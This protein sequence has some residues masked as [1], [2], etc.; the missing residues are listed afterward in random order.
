MKKILLSIFITIG[1]YSITIAQGIVRGKI[2]DESGETQIGVTIVVKSNPSVGTVTDLDGNYSLN[3]KDSTTQTLV[4]S[5]IG[6]ELIEEVVH[7]KKG[8]VVI[9]NF[10][11]KSTA[12]QIKEI[13]VNAKGN[14]AKDTYIESMKKSSSVTLDYISSETIKKTGDANVTAAVA[15]VSGVST[16]GS[17]ITVRGI[18]DRYVKTAINGLR[19]PTLDPFTNNIKLDLFPASL[20][21]NVIITKTESPDLPGDFAGAYISVETKDYPEQLAVNIES[22]FGYNSQTTFN[23]IVSSQRSSTDK[24][25]FDNNFRDHDHNLFIQTIK[26]PTDYQQFVALGLGDY[27]TSLG[28]TNENWNSNGDMYYR[29]GLVQLGLLAPV[30]IDDNAAY[31]EARILYITGPYSQQAFQIINANVP[32]SGQSFKNNWNTISRK[33]PLDF[34]QSFSI[35]TQTNLFGKPLGFIVGYRYGSSTKYDP[36][37]MASKIRA[38]GSRESLFNGEHSEEVN[39]WSAIANVAYKF[40]PN[41]SV[42][43]LFMPNLSGANKADNL[44]DNLD[45]TIMIYKKIQFYEQRKQLVYQLKSEH[46]F[47]GNKIRAEFNASYTDGNSSVPDFK[48]LRYIYR[49]D[50]D[51]WQ[52]G[53]DNGDI[54]R[55][56][57]YLS[58]NLFDSKVSIKI[59]FYDKPGLPRKLKLGGAYQYNFKEN[60]QY[61]YNVQFGIN[62]DLTLKNGNIDEFFD[63]NNFGFTDGTLSGIPYS[64]IKEYYVED[65]TPANHTFGKSEIAAGFLMI[66][67]TIIPRLRFSGGVRI[68]HA[69]LYTDVFKF[70]SMGYQKNDP[71][72]NYSTSYPLVNPG[73]LSE[74]NF[75]PS[76]NLIFKLNRD[77]S[78]NNGTPINLRLNYSNSIARPSLRELSDVAQLD[79]EFKEFVF[80]NSDLKTVHINNYDLRLESYFKS[81]DNISISLLYKN[82]KNHIELVRSVGLTWQNVDH[83]Y[84][85]GIELEG[86]KIITKNFEFRANGAL[87]KSQT[88]FIR[89]RVDI[90][91]GVKEYIPIDT[92]T[93]TMFGQAPYVL[94]GMLTYTSDSIGLSFTVSYN[95]QGERLVIT[96]ANPF[97]PD[98]YELPRQMVDIKL[99]KKFGKHFSTSLTVRDI[100]NTTIT[101]TYKDSEFIYDEFSYGTNFLI[102]VSY[103]L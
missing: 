3:L 60:Q 82:F 32:E 68:E 89:N 20:V 88:K 15:R 81:G 22:S 37:Y 52:I 14:H 30:Q 35:G 39:G 6:Y 87:L 13:V 63:L 38:D 36:G 4:V 59:P 2:T 69:E 1:I 71:R 23:N 95:V 61:D 79:Y 25:G 93:R 47:P 12:Q 91:D 75:L 26:Q 41:H 78:G 96:S 62:S 34:S 101:R 16:N 58:D 103:K 99:I 76:A 17:F 40:S 74:T 66:D 19:I 10:I 54:D 5:S 100:L 51:T 67:Y 53:G 29:L 49:K 94:N 55:Y 31:Q 73:I 48:T 85:A 90:S 97:I 24:F 72:R 46:F 45:S 86:K 7:P 57:R 18:G 56:Y 65:G 11:L 8:E 27:Y 43:F 80:G 9:K 33:A 42:S 44:L 83:S 50:I 92:L 64:T 28:V 70:D 102:G 84:V 98:V 21:D 77:S